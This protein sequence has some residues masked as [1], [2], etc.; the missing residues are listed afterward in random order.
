MSLKESKVKYTG[1]VGGKEGEGGN[2]VSIFQFQKKR[3]I[4]KTEANLTNNFQ[5][6]FVL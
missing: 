6:L 1:R 4:L 3:N 5:K 2:D